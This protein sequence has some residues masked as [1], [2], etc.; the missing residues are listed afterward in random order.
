MGAWYE[1]ATWRIL[2]ALMSAQIPIIAAVHS[3]KSFVRDAWE[4]E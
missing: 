1:C 2:E 4:K 3:E